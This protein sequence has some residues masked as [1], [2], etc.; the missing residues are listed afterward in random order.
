MAVYLVTGAAGFIGSN[1]VRALLDRGEKV[2]G[3]DNFSTGKPQNLDDLGGMEFHEGDIN[4]S[5]LMARACN[6]VDFVL[7]Q[8]ALPSVPRSVEDPESCNHACIDGTLSVLIAARDAKVRRVIYAGSS[9][10]YGDSQTLPKSEGMIPDPI[11]PYAVA[12]LAGEYYMKS[13]WR[14][15]GLETVTLRYFNVFGP[16]QDP[17]S[18]YSGVLAKFITAML[19][20]EQPVIF[21]D[22]EQ[23]RD[24]TYIENVVRGNL[25]ACAAPPEQVAGKMFNVAT[26]DRVSLN[27]TLKILADLIGV[28]GTAQY[29]APRTGDILHSLADISQAQKALGYQV[30][31]PF[32]E[33]LRRTVEWY[34]SQPALKAT[35]G[36]K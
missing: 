19:A 2:R 3:V 9:S 31:V 18:F 11:S 7:H 12:K 1:I 26:G 23:T 32:E 17:T 20:G 30:T 4:D 21:G 16:H 28:S 8:A 27:Q 33:G 35:S 6:G 10:A 5:A 24:F 15:Y 25:L 14:V 29:L 13:F 22:G 34:R 36:S